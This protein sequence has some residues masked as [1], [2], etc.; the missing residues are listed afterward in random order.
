MILA[1]ADIILASLASYLIQHL[2]GVFKYT[3]SAL[4]RISLR[5]YVSGGDAPRIFLRNSGSPVVFRGRNTPRSARAQN[6]DSESEGGLFIASQ[7]GISD[8]WTAPA[9]MSHRY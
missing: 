9:V 4:I 1:M 5:I 2:N 6:V 8:A 3:V 7:P